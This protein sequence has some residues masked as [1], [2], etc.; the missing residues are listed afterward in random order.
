MSYF[1]TTV[2]HEESERCNGTHC[3][4][5][6]LDEMGNAFEWCV[7]CGHGYR[8]EHD[9]VVA[10]R[11]GLLKTLDR[12][13]PWFRGNAFKPS[14]ASILW[15]WWTAKSDDVKFCPLCLHDF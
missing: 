12:S 13:C 10:Y 3:H 14:F 5:C 9:L 8:T 2:E 6:G 11:R 7:E 1:S 4:S 15:R